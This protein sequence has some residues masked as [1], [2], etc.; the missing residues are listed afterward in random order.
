MGN[1]K[2]FTS[3]REN[4]SIS[5]T[6]STS[7]NQDRISDKFQRKSN[8]LQ[9]SW[10]KYRQLDENVGQEARPVEPA[11]SERARDRI[12]EGIAFPGYLRSEI[13]RTWKTLN[14]EGN[15]SSSLCVREGVQCSR[16]RYRWYKPNAK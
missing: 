9:R 6:I 16:F 11:T 13:E 2:D 12:C 7:N 3:V 5:T 14:A 8:S 10:R 15:L 4:C 1:K